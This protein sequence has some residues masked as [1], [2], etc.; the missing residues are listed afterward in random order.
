MTKYTEIGK[1]IFNSFRLVVLAQRVAV[2]SAREALRG[3]EVLISIRHSSK[4][5]KVK[6]PIPIR[7]HLF[8]IN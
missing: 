3:L 1:R 2:S 4:G 5:I 6:H 8:E 7:V